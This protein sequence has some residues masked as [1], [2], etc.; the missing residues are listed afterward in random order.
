MLTAPS[1]IFGAM[2]WG[3]SS[4]DLAVYDLPLLGGGVGKESGGC[5]KFFLKSR[6]LLVLAPPGPGSNMRRA[7]EVRK[8]LSADIVV[9]QSRSTAI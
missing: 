8:R 3:P 9:E 1:P 5:H 7:P 6:L 2:A 4:G